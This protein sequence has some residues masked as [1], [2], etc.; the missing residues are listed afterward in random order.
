MGGL[1]IDIM[2]VPGLWIVTPVSP[3]WNTV[4]YPS[5]A[6]LFTLMRGVLSPGNMSASHALLVNCSK[7]SSVL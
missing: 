5:L 4:V 2:I 1:V 3:E 7:G 6:N